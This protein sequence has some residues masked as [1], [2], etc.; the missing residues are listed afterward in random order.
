MIRLLPLTSFLLLFGVVVSAQAVLKGTVTDPEGAFISGAK[1]HL[2]GSDS[3]SLLAFTK[4]GGKYEIQVQPGK[5]DLSFSYFGFIPFEINDFV[6]AAEKINRFD[7]VLKPRDD[8]IIDEFQDV[9]APVELV[10]QES[11]LSIEIR[12]RP[13]VG[14]GRYCGA[15]RDEA[16]GAIPNVIVSLTPE[17]RSKMGR[18]YEF[19]AD[20]DGKFDSLVIDGLYKISFK[21]QSYNRLE[22]RN[23]LL[24]V[25]SNSCSE[26]R[27]KSSVHPYRIT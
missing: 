14:M 12:P 7:V 13:L 6:A 5:Y 21:M 18:P 17:T 1:I 20:A 25:N 27:L 15:V 3:R 9:Y 16:G 11:A 2:T 19:K 8:R 10:L 22:L 26:I 4:D 23:Q 24:P